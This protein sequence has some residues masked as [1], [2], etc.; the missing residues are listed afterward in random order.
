MDWDST[1]KTRR[2]L[3]GLLGGLGAAVVVGGCGGGDSN[4]SG[5]RRTS[6]TSS[7]TSASSSTLAG[8]T[9]TTAATAATLASC[10]KIPQETAGPYPGDGTN[11][12]NALTVNGIVRSDIRPSVGS[13]STTASG[14]PLTIRLTVVDPSNG[15]RPRANAAVYLW[16]CDAVGRYSMYSQG[17]TG[18]NFL[19]GV[20]TTDTNGNLTFTSVFPGAYSGRWPHI[21]F[22]IFSSAASATSGN[23]KIGVSQ[24]ALPEDVC[25][26][27]YA[28]SGYTGSASNLTQTPITRDNVFSDGYT[29]QMATM[30]GSTAAGYTASLVV[31][32]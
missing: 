7:A 21:H 4:A 19:R 10:T 8:T 30:S 11:G 22:E 12:P 29:Q 18:E 17:V 23:N 27:V 32:S 6:T 16:H 9:S 5:A 13:G 28:T 25:R 20:Q 14:V 26:A 1:R 15:C 2:E 24:L 31:A 3:L